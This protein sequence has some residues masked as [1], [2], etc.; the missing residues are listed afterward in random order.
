MKYAANNSGTNLHISA[1]MRKH[2]AVIEMV[3]G[4]C[5]IRCF[6]STSLHMRQM[7]GVELVLPANLSWLTQTPV[8]E[9]DQHGI[10]AAVDPFDGTRFFYLDSEMRDEDQGIMDENPNAV[11]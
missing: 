5:G 2:L 11:R 1:I 3:T 7:Y 4:M 8:V 9:L 10:F 6:K